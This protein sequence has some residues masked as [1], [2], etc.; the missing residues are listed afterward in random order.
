MLEVPVPPQRWNDA[1]QPTIYA[2][3]EPHVAAAEKLGQLARSPTLRSARAFWSTAPATDEVF[4]L[5]FDPSVF[6]ASLVD[7]TQPPD[8]GDFMTPDYSPSQGFAINLLAIGMTALR[9]PSSV[10]WPDVHLNEAYYVTL[11]GQPQRGDFPAVHEYGS[12][13]GEP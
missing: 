2:S 10:F 4:I 3:H 8:I 7:L 9:A 5:S 6:R 11:A 12:F 1:H 13:K